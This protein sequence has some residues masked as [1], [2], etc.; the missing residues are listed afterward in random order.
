[1]IQTYT[2][3]DIDVNN[4]K[5][6]L[7]SD[8]TYYLELSLDHTGQSTL[9]LH[10]TTSALDPVITERRDD[11]WT[12]RWRAFP[13]CG[14]PDYIFPEDTISL[15]HME[16]DS[17]FQNLLEEV[18]AGYAVNPAGCGVFTKPAFAADRCLS[19]LL[20]YTAEDFFWVY[21]PTPDPW[22]RW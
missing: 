17:D 7:A 2:H 21:I 4:P 3:P 11:G 8:E 16:D 15:D 14:R 13:P 5:T 9:S 18:Y 1:M 6:N 12:R 19:R 22:G 10:K 20:D